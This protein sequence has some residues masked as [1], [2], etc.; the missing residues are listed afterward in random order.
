MKVRWTL[1]NPKNIVVELI[2]DAEVYNELPVEIFWGIPHDHIPAVADWLIGAHTG[3]VLPDGWSITRIRMTDTN[4]GSRGR[5]EKIE[6]LRKYM[7]EANRTV[8]ALNRKLAAYQDG[9]LDLKAE[10]RRLRTQ[11]GVSRM[12]T[13]NALR[14]LDKIESVIDEEEEN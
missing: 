7:T 12:E 3:L 14:K 10:N 6:Q 13:V 1:L 2:E 8:A 11:L 4:D 9:A 5:D